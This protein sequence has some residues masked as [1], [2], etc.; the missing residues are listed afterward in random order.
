MNTQTTARYSHLV[1]DS[2][3]DAANLIGKKIRS[4]TSEEKIHDKF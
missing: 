1:G 2:L 3:K 4:A